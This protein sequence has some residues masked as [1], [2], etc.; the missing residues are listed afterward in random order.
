MLTT[1]ELLRRRGET[2]IGLVTPYT[3]DVQPAIVA[4]FAREGVEVVSE[5]HVGLRDNFSFSASWD[6]ELDDMIGAVAVAKP[7]AI[8]VL[9]T[10]FAAAP[11]VDALEARRSPH[12]D[13]VAAAVYG[14]LRTAGGR[15]EQIAGFGRMFAEPPPIAG[16]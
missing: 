5:R 2:R 14:A 12:Y 11:I 4:G 6:G 15:P 16:R 8:V 7:E 3:D 10:N 9:C 13:S 1:F